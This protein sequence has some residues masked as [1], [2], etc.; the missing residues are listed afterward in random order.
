VSN[1][2]EQDA[3]DL[4]RR[5][6][7]RKENFKYRS[8]HKAKINARKRLLYATD[9]EY[10][11]KEIAN[12]RKH[13]LKRRY[14]MSLDDYDGLAKQQ[15]GRCAICRKVET[16]P[17]HLC[18]DHNHKSNRVRALLCYPCNSGLGCYYDDPRLM[19]T[20]P[21]YLEHWQEI[22]KLGPDPRFT[23]RTKG[24]GRDIERPN[25]R[26]QQRQPS[27]APG[28]PARAALPV[29]RPRRAD[30]RQAAAGREQPRAKGGTGGRRG[31]QGSPRL[32]RRQNP[33]RRPRN[34]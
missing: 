8:K 18:V 6:R 2:S 33:A 30:G 20:A 24:K 19:R 15:K 26:R 29:R 28:D 3:I 16:K 5:E 32:D 1:E 27:D 25:A 17:R 14:G 11:A 31:D 4:Q 13:D 22:E 34:R 21:D 10:R 12:K 9:P 23:N 7:R